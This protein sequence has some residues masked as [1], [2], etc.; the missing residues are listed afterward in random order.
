MGVDAM[1]GPETRARSWWRRWVAWFRT[2][3]TTAEWMWR[4]GRTRRGQEMLAGVV[5]PPPLADGPPTPPPVAS[6]RRP[7]QDGQ[8]AQLVT[9]CRI[10]AVG[11]PC[12]TPCDDCRRT[13]RDV[14]RAQI[15][16]GDDADE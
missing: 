3:E 15:Q 1:T 6:G 4:T 11:L 16:M 8:R 14:N 12:T 13:C 5:I 10:F 7:A 9:W 2:D